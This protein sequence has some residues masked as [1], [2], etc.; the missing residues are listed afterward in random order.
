MLVRLGMDV[1]LKASGHWANVDAGLVTIDDDLEDDLEDEDDQ[2]SVAE[3][4]DMKD[5]SVQ[6][7]VSPRQAATHCDNEMEEETSA[8]LQSDLDVLVVMNV[9]TKECQEKLKYRRVNQVDHGSSLPV[10]L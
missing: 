1:L 10:L 9:V 3:D 4:S 5:C 6:D 2:C 8:A 7:A